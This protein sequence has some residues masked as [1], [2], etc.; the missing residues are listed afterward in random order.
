MPTRHRLQPVALGAGLAA[1]FC[2]GAAPAQEPCTDW[3]VEFTLT[4]PGQ[5]AAAHALATRGTRSTSVAHGPDGFLAFLPIAD[6][7]QLLLSS[8]DGSDWTRMGNASLLDS[9]QWGN[10]LF[11]GGTVSGLGLYIVTSPDGRRWD[12]QGISA[13]EYGPGDYIPVI[14]TGREFAIL[15][16]EGVASSLDDWTFHPFDGSWTASDIAFDGENYSIVGRYSVSHGPGLDRLT[17]QPFPTTRNPSGIEFGNG[18]FAGLEWTT[19]PSPRAILTSP[20]GI[21]WSVAHEDDEPLSGLLFTGSQFVV[22]GSAGRILTSSDGQEWREE[23]LTITGLPAGHE[24]CSTRPAAWDG[25][26]LVGYAATSTRC[27]DLPATS[28]LIRARCDSL[29]PT[30]VLPSAAHLDGIGGSHW[31]TDLVLHNPDWRETQV[32]IELLVRDQANPTPEW[33]FVVLPGGRSLRIEDVVGRL[34]AFEGAAPLRVTPTATAI[35]ASARTYNDSG[36]GSYGQL[37]EGI[38]EADA[39]PAGRTAR[40]IGLAESGRDDTGF[41]TNLGLVSVSGEPMEVEV[42]L[43]NADGTTLGTLTVEL[44]PWESVQLDRV[45]TSTTTEPID[46]G[47]ALVRTATPAGRFFAYA[48]VIDNRTH[49]PQYVPAR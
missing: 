45:F 5:P 41:R 19:Q 36:S 24:L 44:A 9:V 26:F 28:S 11:A 29:G 8:H 10:G 49:D 17:T 43:R 22:G 42:E 15:A 46:A 40:L 39:I 33:R 38:A 30:L 3:Q 6:D 1:L 27:F 21:A 16:G 32:R 34:F 12:W 4:R 13:L 47:L 48:S 20:D 35:L 37:I 14:W 25:R 31:R 23:R 18:G 7:G 2:A